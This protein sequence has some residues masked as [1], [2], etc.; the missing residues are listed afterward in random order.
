MEAIQLGLQLNWSTTGKK[1]VQVLSRSDH[2]M[3][4]ELKQFEKG[5]VR[6]EDTNV[7]L[8]NLFAAIEAEAD[9][10]TLTFQGEKKE[11]H[12]SSVS[13]TDKRTCKYGTRCMDTQCTRSHP[14]EHMRSKSE[15][16]GYRSKGKGSKGTKGKGGSG[17]GA[18]GK[19][20]KGGKSRPACEAQGCSQTTPHPSKTLCTTCFKK[21]IETG[22]ITKKDGTT[23]VLKTKPASESNKQTSTSTYG[24]SAEQL[25]G[26]RV[27]QQ[28]AAY[29]AEGISAGDDEQPAP[30]STKRARIAERLGR[31][32][33]ARVTQDVDERTTKFLNAINRQ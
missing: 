32:D 29:I 17:K 13:V 23:F 15:G 19:G 30:A 25:E 1:I 7:Y 26:L 22:S 28:S 18:K 27:M 11:W 3:A 12:A 4:Q 14:G 24:F 10:A 5:P 2:V 6:P 16:D 9:K 31:A 21:V 20:G 33:A 8:Q